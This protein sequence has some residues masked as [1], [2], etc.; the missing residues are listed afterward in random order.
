MV[1]DAAPQPADPRL[2]VPRLPAP[3][4][5]AAKWAG[6]A[7]LL[8]VLALA[9]LVAFLHTPPGRQF[10]IGQIAAY[11]PASGM[12]VE[13]GSIEGS[14]LW[15]ATFND[16][17]LR[18]AD[19]VEFLTV[20]RVELGWRPWKWFF[21]GLD[22][23]HL[24]LSGGT[25]RSVPRLEPGD[26]DAP[27]L[28]DFNIAVDRFVIE[29]LT[30]AEGLLG[31]ERVIQLRSS[32]EVRRGR[33]RIDA[34]GEL[35]G[36][37]RF[38]LLVDA[39]PDGNVFDIDLDWRAPAGGFLA[40]MVGA[41]EDLA[42]VVHGDGSWTRWEGRIDATQGGQP[43]VAAALVNEA[44]QYRLVGEA[45]P[46][47]NLTGLPAR[48]MGSRIGFNAMGTL[49][50]ST[51]EG[52]FALRGQGLD[53]DG[54]GG[55]DL[56]DNRF[57]RLE[58]EAR[59]LDP[60]LLVAGVQLQ[61]AG[62]TMLLDGPFDGLQV[63]HRLSIGRIV[64]D[65]V[66][67]TDITQRGVLS[68][69]DGRLMVPLNAAVARVVSGNAVADPLLASGRLTGMLAWTR[70]D[71]RLTS[72]DLALRFTGLEARLALTGDLDRGAF[73]LT[74]P[75]SARGLALADV[76]VVDATAGIDLALGGGQPWR[77]AAALDGR[78]AQVTNTSITTLVGSDVRFAGGL[79]L[80]S[81]RPIAFADL[82]LTGSKLQAV[83]DGQVEGGTTRLTGHGQHADYGPFTVEATLAG[84]GP[85]ARLVLADPY[86]DAGLRDVAVTLAPEGDGFAIAA[87][88]QSLL[89]PFDGQFHLTLP[90]QGP[91]TIAIARLD[92]GETR[93]SGQLRLA[94]GGVDGAL[95]LAGGGVTGRIELAAR[96]EGQGFAIVLDAANA[97]FGGTTPLTVARG[98]VNLAGLVAGASSTVEGTLRA[99]GIGYGQL[100][101]GRVAA[102]AQ[103]IDGRGTF[104]AAL[105]GRRGSRFELLL[106]GDAARERIA[107]AASGSYAGQPITM[108]RR[109]VL[110]N[111]G[112]SR[113]ELEPTQV[114]YGRGFLIANGTFGGD[115]PAEGQL[116][117]SD[118]PL[119]LVDALAGDLGLGGRVSG[120]IDLA[121]DANGRP[122]GEARVLVDG[123][124]RSG[125]VLTSRPLDLAL[126]ARLTAGSLHTRAVMRGEAGQ[127][128]SGRLDARISGLPSEGGL[129]ARLYAG[130][131]AGSLRYA[132]PAESLWRLAA[133]DMIDLTGP[134]Q[135]NATLR[136]TLAAPRLAGS[137]AGEGM[138]V[139]SALTGSDI[140]NV[141]ARGR[142]TDSRLQ[143][144]SFAGTAP[145]GGRV[146]GSGTIDLSGVTR[147]RGP[148]LD[149]RLAAANARI[150]Q[151]PG[152]GATVTGPMRI[153]SDGVGGTI[154]G[155]LD[156]RRAE[157]RLGRAAE[158]V[159]L[160]DIA[161]TEVNSPAD[162]A[163]PRRAA[164]PWRY[165]ID[166]R[167]DRGIEVDGMGLDSEWSGAVRLRGTTADPRIGGQVRIVPRQGF[168]TFAGSRF[169]ITRG[170]ITFDENGPPDPRIDILAEAEVSGVDFDVTVRGTSSQPEIA[171][172][173]VPALPE[174]ELLSRLLFGGSVT[175]ISA[176]DALQLGSALA[177]LRG[178]GGMD[179]INRLRSAVGLDRLR[180][181]PADAA[182][183]RGTSVAL[184]KNITRRFYVELVTDGQG[185]NATALEFRVTGWLSLLAAINTVGQG[186]VEAVISRDY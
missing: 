57:R 13:V 54:S 49:A 115:E 45:W 15:S 41:R 70:A 77:L 128:S 166:A 33:V 159:D 3:V 117:L 6:R 67:L 23:R 111:R 65:G 143:L 92:V 26:P 83:L 132:G 160:P 48:A 154:A 149:I 169:E 106:S 104:D 148:Q 7:L 85:R 147:D 126:V 171:F 121:A 183:G 173:S 145:N 76:G 27:I 1:D 9:G 138:R 61:Q 174:E 161:I 139:Q 113:W 163:P 179:P 66:V 141:A 158:V 29:D 93:T 124:T 28:P 90:P 153:V 99:E 167:A 170:L 44:G 88:G 137:L 175:E 142:F 184:G 130:Q 182:L 34:E 69:R 51:L 123:L 95:A 107:V 11:A 152:M 72:R 91:T 82:R 21:S 181:V 116:A 36:Q 22:V 75:V 150:L 144:V 78:L 94:G 55:I 14:V 176:T 131:L 80:G 136:G 8:L 122:V 120:V 105:A 110:V 119:T 178:G 155:R 98:Q 97:R 118:M 59:L 185:Y 100:F 53:L 20:P 86:P 103:V 186:Q 64:A 42:I 87:D 38:A 73:R 2:P 102:N 19:G 71:N 108:P 30:V 47:D 109:A 12:T 32:A 84:D 39:E 172:S 68:Y 37:D 4:L 180:I 127:A 96:P 25:L 52:S 162:I 40:T 56:G 168:Y 79:T 10:L 156:V 63:P 16:V 146:S 177:S 58:L 157:W 60:E 17:H 129:V 140:S 165:L 125:L 112:N 18:D 134:L 81:G 114:S 89:G 62:L 74:G 101:L 5:M 135:V 31:E 35:G 164:R 46:G 151:L 24:V 43:L 50:D 133:L